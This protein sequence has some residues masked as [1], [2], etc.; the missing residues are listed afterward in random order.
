MFP[1]WHPRRNLHVDGLGMFWA[2]KTG[3]AIGRAPNDEAKVDTL[4]KALF[5]DWCWSDSR[6]PQIGH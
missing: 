2:Y 3:D 6:G 4:K 5:G 1:L